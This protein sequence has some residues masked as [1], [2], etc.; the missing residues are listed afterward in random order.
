MWCAPFRSDLQ[1]PLSN[2]YGQNTLCPSYGLHIPQMLQ[3]SLKIHLPKGAAIC[4]YKRGI[5]TGNP[6]LPA[7]PATPGEPGFPAG[8]LLPRFPFRPRG[9]GAPGG[10][11]HPP[12]PL[13]IKELSCRLKRDLPLLLCCS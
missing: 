8:P 6:F 12:P 3:K 10:Q 9:P 7:G 5:V 2:W 11:T 4:K 13:S 1:K